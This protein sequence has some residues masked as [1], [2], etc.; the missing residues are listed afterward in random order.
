MTDP[1]TPLIEFLDRLAALAKLPRADRIRQARAEIEEHREM[2]MKGKEEA[3][4][5]I[6]EKVP[7]GDNPQATP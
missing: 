2:L 6:L 1:D 3:T 4:L 5:S 7:S